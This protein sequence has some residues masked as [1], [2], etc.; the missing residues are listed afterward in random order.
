MRAA[1]PRG[2]SP[3][4]GVAAVGGGLRGGAAWGRE[5]GRP[6]LVHALTPLG[7]PGLCVTTCT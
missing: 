4:E 7:P 5:G 3:G 1:L 6:D 2:C